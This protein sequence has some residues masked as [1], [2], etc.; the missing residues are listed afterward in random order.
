MVPVADQAPVVFDHAGMMRRMV[1]DED[2]ARKLSSV[3]LNDLPGLI[4]TLRGHLEAGDVPST[5]RL[6]HTIK[7]GAATFGGEALRA[8]AF[9]MEKAA[10]A[11]DLETVRE[12]L[13]AME[14]EASRLQAALIKHFN[15]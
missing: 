11:G 5:E 8:V 10:K 14:S 6:A 13:P 7:S 1:D 4:K 3:F 12:R 15:L 9:K 2:M